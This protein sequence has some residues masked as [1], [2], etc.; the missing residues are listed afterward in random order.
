M[1]ENI[2]RFVPRQTNADPISIL[3]YVLENHP[4]RLPARRV[5]AGFSAHLT[6]TG[7]AEYHHGTQSHHLKAGDLFFS[8]PAVPIGMECSEDFSYIYISYLGSRA[9]LIMEQLRITPSNCV[10]PDMGYL[11]ELWKSGLSIHPEMLALRS[12]SILMFT[13]SEIG[14]DSSDAARSPRTNQDSLLQIRKFIDDNF[15]DPDLSLSSVS[16][17][18]SYHPKYLSTAFKSMFRVNFTDYLNI[19]RIQHACTLMEQSFTCV[20]DIA[21]LCGFRDPMYFSRVFRAR[22]GLSPRQHMAEINR[23]GETR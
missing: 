22:M 12:E 19:L 1:Q 10:F 2:C 9:N 11:T 15:S 18:F 4:Q 16:R 23:R 3:H 6:L 17:A 20:K 14:K 5:T 13:F 21:S 8:L 7:E